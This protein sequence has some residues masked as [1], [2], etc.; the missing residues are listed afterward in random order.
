[1]EGSCLCMF[2]G[3]KHGLPSSMLA[4]PEV[5]D[6]YYD[7]RLPHE[8]RADR[9]LR[10]HGVEEPR[11]A[12]DAGYSPKNIPTPTENRTPTSTIAGLTFAG[13]FAKLV[14]PQASTLPAAA[15]RTPPLPRRRDA[16]FSIRVLRPR[17]SSSRRTPRG[18][19]PTGVSS[20]RFR[21]L[22]RRR[23]SSRSRASRRRAARRRRGGD[24]R[25]ASRDGPSR[26]SPA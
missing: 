20:S 10:Q 15:P 23:P 7:T 25:F 11:D 9:L 26:R 4:A 17:R 19:S 12:F 24:R 8:T 14:I 1:M 22:A 18:T 3:V 21:S 5:C 16:T 2:Q 6:A 13:M